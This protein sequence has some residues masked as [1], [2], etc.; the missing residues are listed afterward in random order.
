[1]NRNFENTFR[2]ISIIFLASL[3]FYFLFKAIYF[4]VTI[5]HLELLGA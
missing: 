2:L 1:M 3:F 5:D 4:F